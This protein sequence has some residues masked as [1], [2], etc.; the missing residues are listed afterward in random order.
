[1]IKIS[2]I[3]PVYNAEKYLEETLKCIEKQTLKDIE[4]ILVNDGSKDRSGEIC[5]R[6]AEQDS[7]IRVI[8]QENKG[9]CASR[10]YAMSIAQGEYIAFADNDDIVSE[11]FLESNYLYA[12]K[13]DADIIKFGR[14]TIYINDQNEDMGGETRRFSNKVLRGKEIISHYFDLQ[15]KGALS[16]VWD[17]LYRKEL[18]ERNKVQFYEDFRYG[19]E[20]TIFCRQLVCYAKTFVLHE[21]CYYYHY[22]RSAYSASAKFNEKALDK[23]KT[24][25]ALEEKIWK[26]LKIDQLNDG[27]KE[28]GVTK[29]YLIPILFMLCDK[30]CTFSYQRKKDYLNM[31]HRQSG[32]KM[33]LNFCKLLNLMK[34]N[35]KQTVVIL[36]FDMK[37]YRILLKVADQYKKVIDDRLKNGKGAV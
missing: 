8:H 18:I 30:N 17:G 12:K 23:Y 5:D 2:L 28:M 20:D 29:D 3:I 9:M 7:R 36:L 25:C 35:K 27:K 4:I 14:R 24:A 21:G 6:F 37:L 34:Q 19:C 1:M 15:K 22:V 32:Y 10:N 16:A 13:T 11:D 31:I 26:K 33:H